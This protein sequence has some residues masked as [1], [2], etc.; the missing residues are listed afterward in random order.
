MEAIF[1]ILRSNHPNDWLLCVEIVELSNKKNPILTAKIITHLDQL[2]T[3]RP[4]VMKL[5]N[6]GLELIFE[7]QY[8]T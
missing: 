4:E 8:S 6:N 7:K 5:I 1:E 3:L 2:K